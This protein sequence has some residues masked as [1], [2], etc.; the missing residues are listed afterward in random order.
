MEVDQILNPSYFHLSWMKWI[1][2]SVIVLLAYLFI[3]LL[4][5]AAA[6]MSLLGGWKKVLHDII[7]IIYVIAE[8]LG[9][10]IVLINFVL[11]HPVLH[12]L[13]VLLI[14]ILGFAVIKSYFL[15]KMMMLYNTCY[16]GQKIKFNDSEGFIK[17]IGRTSLTLQTKQGA[18]HISYTQIFNKG[19][20]QLEGKDI[21]GL[22]SV[23]IDASDVEHNNIQNIKDL[24][25][26]SPYLDWS[27]DP[28]VSLTSKENQFIVKVLL[29]ER[30]HL[31]DLIN[32]ISEWGYKCHL[33]K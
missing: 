10:F 12:G 32:L 4:H 29:S 33:K 1:I 19:F 30:G 6:K 18:Q 22:Q 20:T 9:I 5:D 14:L 25:W 7:Y 24:L 11:I 17:E 13:L 8:P 27:F 26:E 31:D 28:E 21:G 23:Y 16:A 15:G 3:R 2:I